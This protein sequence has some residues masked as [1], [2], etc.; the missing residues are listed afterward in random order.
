MSKVRLP[1]PATTFTLEMAMSCPL[2]PVRRTSAVENDHRATPSLNVT[3]T[4]ASVFALGPLGTAL[5]ICGGAGGAAI[6]NVPDQ[7]LIFT[8]LVE[9]M[10]SGPIRTP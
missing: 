3:R 1:V 8:V 7:M 2:G 5:V 6:L 4:E 10:T 9:F